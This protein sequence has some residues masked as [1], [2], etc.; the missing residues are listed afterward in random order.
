[1]RS[2]E[3]TGLSDTPEN[4]KLLEATALVISV[5]IKK[6]SFDYIKHFPTGNK[7][8]LFKPADQFSPSHI[9]VESY[10]KAWIKAGGA[11]QGRTE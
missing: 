6:K 1:M 11:C 3:G 8:R 4:R 10:F 7:A 5:E 9:T 2:W